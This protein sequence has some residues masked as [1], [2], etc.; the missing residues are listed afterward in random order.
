MTWKRLAARIAEMTDEEQK[1]PVYCLANGDNIYGVI[2]EMFEAD[3]ACTFEI[4]DGNP[5]LKI[6]N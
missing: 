3:G 5:I 6:T 2:V 4:A 1:R